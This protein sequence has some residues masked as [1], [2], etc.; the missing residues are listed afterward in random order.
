MKIVNIIGG[1]GNQM[2]QYAFALSLQKAYPDE[3]VLIDTSHFNYI[4]VKKIKGIN[5][6]NGFELSNLYP[7]AILKTATPTQLMKISWYVPNYILGRCI[8]KLLP[9]KSTELKEQKY[10]TF[11]PSVYERE[12]NTYY[13]GY[14]QHYEYFENNKDE[15]INTF[16]ITNDLDMVN[17]AFVKSVLLMSNSISIHVRRGDF[18]KVPLYKGICEVDY[19]ERAIQKAHELVGK[20]V[21][22][23]IF[24]NDISWCRKYL[25]PYIGANRCNFI[26][27]NKGKD[28]FKDMYLMRACRCNIIAN[29]SFSWWGAYLNKREDKI[30]IAPDKWVNL[31]VDNPIQLPEWILI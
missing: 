14:W 17:R 4:F 20:E 8:S 16:D 23:F 1:L 7:K 10:G 9:N 26:D 30:V 24:S 19:Y 12:G 11:Y 18:L 21:D 28:S 27:W 6:H 3:D 22:F 5:L 15:I 13:E 29:S 2:F 31:P 25:S